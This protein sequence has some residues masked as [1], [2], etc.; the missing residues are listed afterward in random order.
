MAGNLQASLTDIP[1]GP[2]RVVVMKLTDDSVIAILDRTKGGCHF[3]FN[4]KTEDVTMDQTADAVAAK[5][6]AGSDALFEVPLVTNEAKILQ[7]L[8]PGTTLYS[9]VTTSEEALLYCEQIGDM[10]AYAVKVRLEPIG[11]STNEHVTLFKAIPVPNIDRQYGGKDI[12]INGIQFVALPD[13]AKNN[14][15]WLMGPESV[16][17]S[18]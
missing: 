11:R 7:P 6:A 2:C 17:P 15:K 9:N 5:L 18:A 4:Q 14:R 8:I 13:P 10:S 12:H 3:K 16:L 1:M